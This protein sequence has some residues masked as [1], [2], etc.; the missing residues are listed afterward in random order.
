ME[1]RKSLLLLKH[2]LSGLPSDLEKGNVISAWFL[3]KYL[4]VVTP[5]RP[6]S[7]QVDF[8]DNEGDSRGIVHWYIPHGLCGLLHEIGHAKHRHSRDKK[9]HRAVEILQE[10]QAWLWA[11]YWCKR[12]GILFDYPDAN[13]SFRTY[14]RRK[15][16]KGG[17]GKIGKQ[18]VIIKWR[19]KSGISLAS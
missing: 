19:Y 6:T 12:L 5:K 1:K 10:A 18:L 15:R 13:K 2:E 3:P 16:R 9:T 14:F 7:W 11:E 17:T 4:L 8:E